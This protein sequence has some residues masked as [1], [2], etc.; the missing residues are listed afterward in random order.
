MITA[1]Y[2]DIFKIKV[3]IFQEM[4]KLRSLILFIEHTGAPVVLNTDA[5]HVYLCPQI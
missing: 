3:Y 4:C 2:S 5:V 1:Q